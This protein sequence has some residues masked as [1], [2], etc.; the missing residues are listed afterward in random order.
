MSNS[1]K[2][3]DKINAST[4]K[5]SELEEQNAALQTLNAELH[6]SEKK[7][8]RLIDNLETEYFFYSQDLDGRYNYVSPSITKLLGY[9]SNEVEY[10][11]MQ[12]LTDHPT[13]KRAIEVCNKTKKGQKQL[14]FEIEIKDKNN[15]LKYFELLE[16]PILNK[17]KEVKIIEGLAHDITKRKRVEQVQK[18][19]ANI[20]NAVLMSDS[21]VGIVKTIREQLST[22]IDAQNFY[23]A[24]YDEET[25]RLSLPFIADEKDDIESF[26]A[27]KT[28]TGYVVKTKK[29]LMATSDQ[30]EAMVKKGQID[31]VGSRSQIWLGV[32]L[33]TKGKVIGV[34][35]VQSYTDVNA[36]SENDRE[37]LEIISN[38]ISQSI[39]RKNMEVQE[40]EQQ[41]LFNQITTSSKDAII[42]INNEGHIIF[43]NK[44]AE[45]IFG[46]TSAE[47]LNRDLHDLIRPEEYKEIQKQAFKNFRKTGK[48]NAIGKTVELTAKR[49]NG[50]EFP[51]ALSLSAVKLKGKWNAIGTVRDIT[52]RKIAEEKLREEK[53][54]AERIL[55]VVPSAVFTVDTNKVITSWNKKA[56]AITGWKAKDVIG[57]SCNMFTG[58]LC[59]N[60]GLYNTEIQKPITNHE[61]SIKIRGGNI[62]TV[63]K[64]VD[65]L[66]DISGNII[67]GIESFEDIS[68][69]KRDE[70]IQKVLYDISMA[71]NT[72]ENVADFISFIQKQ[73][74]LLFDTTNFYV[75]FY[76][77]DSD[78]LSTAYIVDE[79]DELDTWPA[80]KSLTG[81]VV[82]SHKTLFIS[83][84]EILDLHKR[85][86]MDIVGTTPE[87][88]VGIPLIIDE[89]VM[90]ALAIQDYNNVNAYTKKDVEFLELISNQLSTAIERKKA[91]EELKRANIYLQEQKEELQQQN[92]ENEQQNEEI[93]AIND[94]MQVMNYDLLVSEA[95]VRRLIEN[96]EDEYIFYSQNISGRYEYM[97]PSAQ[98]LLGYTAKE[99]EFGLESFLT[100]NEL[101]HEAL[102]NFKKV[103]KGEKQPTFQIEI[104]DKYEQPRY[105]EILRGAI[106]NK[107]NEITHIEG[108]AHEIT[109]R[110][111]A[112]LIQSII[113]NISNAVILSDDLESLI[114]IIQDELSKLLDTRN[115]YVA[116]FDEKTQIVSF[117]FFINEKDKISSRVLGNSLTDY[118]IKSGKSL[119][120]G[121][122][123]KIKMALAALLGAPTGGEHAMKPPKEL[124][125]QWVR[126]STCQADASGYIRQQYQAYGRAEGATMMLQ[127]IISY[128]E[129]SGDRLVA[130]E[131]RKEYG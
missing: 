9:D 131:L 71:V 42:V 13:N 89:G 114:K 83:K 59:S 60:C 117:P 100:K 35:T 75:A 3:M 19:L 98:R 91:A 110:K 16:I 8:K 126:D 56:E 101:N 4:N 24:L 29:T 99:L 103:E 92:E 130:D 55:S 5:L 33:K 96:L 72:T 21:L 51:A 79:K 2:N 111:K 44:S 52:N 127:E 66:K 30:Q 64:N 125:R 108:I 37:I 1:K 80:G 49:K 57:K 54:Y 105:F 53:E 121:E 82:K 45:H 70:L 87:V 76:D 32:P 129:D 63:L 112:E 27:E 17:K 113:A 18:I 128:L 11:I 122:P 78:M 88:W 107:N 46:Y 109:E 61:C 102:K 77:S 115:F 23:I 47:V 31:F 25:D 67:G 120:A 74:G 123:T 95:K 28:M 116:L 48:G 81:T 26:P 73:L 38:Q 68:D 97:S 7:F 62:I 15:N 93:R 12:F 90:G 10:G 39:A 85:G 34:M 20:S 43:W 50:E 58:E 41:E 14:P 94:E 106:Y 104:F 6:Q 40:K 119:I 118:V 69:R 65:Y 124:V 36:Y 86:E 22:I 84:S